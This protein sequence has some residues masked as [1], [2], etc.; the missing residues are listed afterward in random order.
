MVLS[1]APCRCKPWS[2]TCLSVPRRRSLCSCSIIPYTTFCTFSGR[3]SEPCAGC[4]CTNTHEVTAHNRLMLPQFPATQGPGRAALAVAATAP[5]HSAGGGAGLAAQSR[6]GAVGG[7]DQ[8]ATFAALCAHIHTDTHA[9]SHSHSLTHS[10]THSHSLTLTHTLTPNRNPT[11]LTQCKQIGR[12]RRS[13]LSVC[14]PIWQSC[15]RGS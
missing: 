13:S 6:R 7:A 2:S 12:Y 3:M 11:L 1:S 4:M 15:A 9:H 14:C 5:L 8:V 10:H